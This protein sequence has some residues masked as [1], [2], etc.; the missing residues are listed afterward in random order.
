LRQRLLPATAAQVATQ[1]GTRY[2]SA[3]LHAMPPVSPSRAI[4]APWLIAT[5]AVPTSNAVTIEVRSIGRKR[6]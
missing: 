6:R 5:S 2:V 3:A 1:N 4:A